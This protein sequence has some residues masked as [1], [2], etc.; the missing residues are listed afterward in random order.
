MIT[1]SICKA[2]RAIVEISRSK[3]AER[4]GVEKRTIEMFER[5]INTPDDE[6]IAAL[7]ST[8]EEL[9]AV[10]LPEKGANG[11]GVRLKFSQSVTRRLA[12]LEGEGGP[13]AKDDVP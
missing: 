9:G 7:R 3:L 10:F 5:G 11:A 12:T 13:T 1:G 4:S 6:A 8:L 2:A